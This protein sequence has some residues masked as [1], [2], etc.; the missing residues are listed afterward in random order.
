MQQAAKILSQPCRH[1]GF[2]VIEL[3]VAMTL[4]AIV[5]ALAVPSVRAFTARVQLNSV[6]NDFTSAVM[7]ARNE[8]VSRNVCITLCM[9]SSAADATPACTSL[10]ADWQVGWIAFI[11]EDCN[12]GTNTPAAAD[13]ILARASGGAE[14]LLQAQGSTP[15][16]K[17]LFNPSGSPGVSGSE[18]FN[19]VYGSVS[20]PMTD[21]YA[22]NICLDGL[23]RTRTIPS[24]QTCA[25]FR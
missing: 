13:L 16:K 2:T 5:A 22:F 14:I 4:M 11:N 7:R 18:Q 8:A 15:T 12:S 6:G 23:G 19:L 1:A 10:G 25:S 24:D 21:R 9:S 17:L 3:L 20:D